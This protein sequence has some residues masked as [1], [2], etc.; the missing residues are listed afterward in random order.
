MQPRHHSLPKFV[1]PEA[2]PILI[3][4]AHCGV[5]QT[6]LDEINQ[7]RYEGVEWRAN[8]LRRRPLAGRGAKLPLGAFSTVSVGSSYVSQDKGLRFQSRLCEL[9]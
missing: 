5:Q 2:S 3:K 1:G 9:F 8:S 7:G 4:P 6:E